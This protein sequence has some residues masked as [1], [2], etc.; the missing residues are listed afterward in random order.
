MRFQIICV[1]PSFPV[2]AVNS[3]VQKNILRVTYQLNVM[4]KLVLVFGDKSFSRVF[5]YSG[6]HFQIH[7]KSSKL[8]LMMSHYDKQQAKVV[9]INPVHYIL[10]EYNKVKSMLVF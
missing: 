10:S 4:K 3:L 8:T 9:L 6:K 2:I 1:G 7:Y 5:L